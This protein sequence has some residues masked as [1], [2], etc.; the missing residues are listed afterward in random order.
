M[1]SSRSQSA[2]YG[3]F[4]S[5]IWPAVLFILLM[6]LLP[7]PI[8]AQSPNVAEPRDEAL[9]D[10]QTL[11][12]GHYCVE[13]V[14]ADMYQNGSGSW[15][16]PRKGVPVAAHLF[17]SG[18]YAMLNPGTASPEEISANGDDTISLTLEDGSIIKAV[19][20]QAHYQFRKYVDVETEEELTWYSY[21][22]SMPELIGQ[23]SPLNGTDGTYRITTS[24]LKSLPHNG[25]KDAE[26][27][28][29]L[30]VVY[31]G[32]SCPLSQVN[33][34]FGLDSFYAKRT[35]PNGP[36]SEVSCVDFAPDSE[37]E[38]TLDVHMFVGGVEA[39]L[40]NEAHRPN[41]IVYITGSN[42]KPNELLTNNLGKQIPFDSAT[43]PYPLVSDEG[44]FDNFKSNINVNRGDSHACFQ[45][46]S[47]DQE[48][49][50]GV[51]AVW[52]GL[53]TQIPLAEIKEPGIKTRKVADSKEVQAGQPIGFTIWVTAT[54]EAISHDVITTDS[55]PTHVGYSWAIDVLHSDAGCLIQENQMTCQWGDMQPGETRQVHIVSPTSAEPL[56]G[57]SKSDLE[58]VQAC[59]VRDENEG[60][61]IYRKK[62]FQVDNETVVTTREELTDQDSD[63]I[64]V[65]CSAPAL[66]ASKLPDVTWQYTA[67]NIGQAALQ[68]VTVHAGENVQIDCGGQTHLNQGD[69]AAC[70]AKGHSQYLNNVGSVFAATNH[71]NPL[72]IGHWH[73]GHHRIDIELDIVINGAI[74]T[75]PPGV[76]T[77]AGSILTVEYRLT[78]RGNV[79]ITN[80]VIDN[81]GVGYCTLPAS[82]APG[83]TQTVCLVNT[84]S[85]QAGPTRLTA[86]VT[87]SYTPIGAESMVGKDSEFG[88]YVGYTQ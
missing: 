11:A 72:Q 69:V 21:H 30:L 59:G 15:T 38:R 44:E 80:L 88:Y 68:N 48:Q 47:I 29:G 43:S 40:P 4:I 46:A 23:N 84:L 9:H 45:I 71:T 17:W 62:S 12:R 22:R 51:S 2:L 19:A 75:I 5:I 3:R 73:T 60:G 37:I 61:K 76:W 52:I 18:R 82:L 49:P 87:G 27:G 26:H 39:Y 81:G 67:T 85:A 42:D 54:G 86:T 55:L 78:N 34:Q 10:V 70:S 8:F 83:E 28:A 25:N 63:R 65:T 1:S 14:G 66:T 32:D 24:D 50:K 33:I 41:D 35:A 74:A 16:I 77:T 53:A 31:E 58:S 57:F 79:P 7:S 6:G 20:E 13:S 64:I 36:N 56:S